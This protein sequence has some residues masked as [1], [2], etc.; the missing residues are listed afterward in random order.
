MTPEE[1]KAKSI[2]WAQEPPT[3]AELR[4]ASSYE[5]GYTQAVK[6]MTSGEPDAWIAKKL[7]GSQEAI[8][9]DKE[10]LE[11]EIE[12]RMDFQE[13]QIKPVKL[14]EV[15]RRLYDDW[16]LVNKLGKEE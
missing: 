6:D 9:Y 8:S 7:D 11:D 13:W 12:E 4:S 14:I 1:I 16:Y 2:Q 15:R 10:V 3:G 5:A